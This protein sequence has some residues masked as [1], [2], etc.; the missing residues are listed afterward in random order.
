VTARANYVI[1]AQDATKDAIRA[2]Q[3]N[4][5]S[6][7][8]SFQST[9]R[10]INIGLGFL[11]GAGL[12]S[13]FRTSLEATAE[14]TGKNS[15]FSQSLDDVKK[16]A[17][18]LLVPKTGLAGVNENLK[19][20]AATLKDPA[21]TSAADALFSAILRGGTAAVN[22]LAQTAA[23]LRII[24]TGSGGNASVDIDMEIERLQ[25]QLKSFEAFGSTAE[26]RKNLRLQISGL[27]QQYDASLKGDS[28]KG[29]QSVTGGGEALSNVLDLVDKQSKG[30]VDAQ[31]AA[32]AY[33]DAI[34]ELAET[35]KKLPELTAGA[36]EDAFKE[37]D[38]YKLQQDAL[39][40]QQQL[41]EE[42]A[43][44]L[45]EQ[46]VRT[47]EWRDRMTEENKRA[48]AQSAD[49]W[50]GLFLD[51]MD[52]GFKGLLR[53]WKRMLK[54][55]AAEGLASGVLSWLKGGSFAGG[56]SSGI[57]TFTKGIGK[58]FGFADGGS[59]QVGGSGGTD[60]QLVAF[61][62]SP[63]ERV[64][65]TK[66]GQGGGVVFSPVY[67]IDARGATI[68][69]ARALPGI[70]ERSSK[71]TEARIVSGLRNGRYDT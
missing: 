6:L 38:P 24:A 61:K 23:G 22:I 65:I 5:K 2:I 70:L 48:A 49:A 55:M 17:Q 62:A 43:K 46:E 51:V 15:E 35:S 45:H 50:K 16:S 8:R 71:A 14:A 53:D 41:N 31:L 29:L 54:E 30:F 20:L 42:A 68:D 3:G 59:F 39:E 40:A 44:S 60:S 18:S 34:K 26:V 64:S 52:D 10:G 1:S 12:K 36:V 69:L 37:T 11:A 21:V 4:L 28:G 47:N 58:L 25:A 67:Q 13:L 19:E 56:F 7:D 27:R 32:E 33:N 63:N 57:D 9:A 66:P